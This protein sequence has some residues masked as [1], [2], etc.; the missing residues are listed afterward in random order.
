MSNSTSLPVVLSMDVDEDDSCESEYR[1]QIGS[2]VKYLVI[3]P[4]TFDRAT[5]SFPVPSLPP[6]P[7]SEWTI[8]HISR[9]ETSRDLQI[10]VS[11]RVLPGVKNQWHPC[12]INCLDLKKVNQLTAMALEA[13]PCSTLNTSL[14]SNPLSSTTVIVKIARFEWE[15]PRI[16]QETRAYQLLEGSSISPRFLGHVHENGR[17]MGFVLDKLAGRAASAGDL[18]SCESAV[19]EF[20]KLGCVHGDLNRFNFLVTD[21]G[22]KVLD[23]ECFLENAEQQSMREELEMLPQLLA[24]ESGRGGGFIFHDAGADA[25]GDVQ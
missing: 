3:S 15:L 16:E 23:F 18:K 7:G 6:L 24:E 9:N 20:H 13:S 22:V 17:I 2:E 25:G 5:L 8:A 21:A 12:V 11:N 19:R 1:V 14:S 4:G 10:T